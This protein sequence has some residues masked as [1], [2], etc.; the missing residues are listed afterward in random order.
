MGNLAVVNG[1]S[2]ST[3]D[4]VCRSILHDDQ[5][6]DSTVELLLVKEYA[7]KHGIENTDAQL[8]LAADELRYQRGLES[9]E[10]TLQWMKEN[11][12]TQLSLQEAIDGM[13]LHNKVRNSIPEDDIAAY[14]AEHQLDLQTVTLYSIRVDSEDKASELYSQITEE[15]ANFH[16]LAME[17]SLDETT[18]PMGGYVGKL[19]RA[20]MTGEIEAAVFQA[21]PGQV[22][23][24]V[25][26][27]KGWNLFKVAAVDKP[28][29]D[30]AKSGIQFTLYR[31]L[32]NKL[33]AEASISYPVLEEAAAV[34][35]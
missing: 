16:V 7:A 21:K 13:L 27:E 14:Y 33:R 24:P 35:D 20:G 1:R 8:Q 34:A 31:A 29:L 2:I 12:Q 17:H 26:T 23:G 30:E 4:A 6:L 15:G 3:A 5:F 19:T 10:K 32:I 18:R 28:S 25:K 11:H 9:V 22:I